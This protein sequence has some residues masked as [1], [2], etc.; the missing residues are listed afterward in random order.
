[1]ALGMFAVDYE[2]EAFVEGVVSLIPDRE[3]PILDPEGP[4]RIVTDI[5]APDFDGPSREVLTVE[6]RPPCVSRHR[7]AGRG[8]E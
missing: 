2:A 3:Q 7:P 1:M 4:V 5:A 6:Q 8:E